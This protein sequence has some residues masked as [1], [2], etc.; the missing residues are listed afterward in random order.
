MILDLVSHLS[1]M[2]IGELEVKRDEIQA[3]RQNYEASVITLK[4]GKSFRIAGIYQSL[5]ELF[6]GR[7]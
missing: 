5:D 4:N 6:R 1:A 2:K 7:R 3:V